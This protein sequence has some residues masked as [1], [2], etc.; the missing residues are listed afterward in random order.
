[1]SIG[2][3]TG[4][5]PGPGGFLTTISANPDAAS[6]MWCVG[7]SYDRD[8]DFLNSPFTG[9]GDRNLEAAPESRGTPRRR[10]WVRLRCSMKYAGLDPRRNTPVRVVYGVSDSP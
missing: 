1:M 8:P 9:F 6:P 5:N 10:H 7:E 4:T 3:S 2:S